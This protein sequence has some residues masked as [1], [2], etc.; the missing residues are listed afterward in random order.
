MAIDAKK[1]ETL[2]EGEKPTRAA[3]AK[4]ILSVND[5][6]P[7]ANRT[8]QQQI[9]AA[10]NAE[11]MPVSASR[12][13]LTTRADAPGMHRAE[14]T[15]GDGVY[16]P[17]SGVLRFASVADAK[18]FGDKNGALLA[19]G[20]R[21]RAGSTDL[22]WIGTGW[23]GD[24][25]ALELKKQ[26]GTANGFGALNATYQSPR[27]RRLVDVTVQ[28][29]I[30]RA[31]GL[32]DAPPGTWIAQLAPGCRPSKYIVVPVSSNGQAR[33]AEIGPDG[34]IVVGALGS[35]SYAR[36]DMCFSFPAEQ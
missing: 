24:W 9:V 17:L 5:A 14:L 29:S 27:Y 2:A 28:G 23:M 4:A 3:L 18:T 13:L 35:W 25:I 36:T 22:E 30:A 33:D 10:L 32:G 16:L 1:H 11:G 20:D 34:R 19:V 7:V 12:P 15:F 6:V 26:D 8:E 21:A 31:A